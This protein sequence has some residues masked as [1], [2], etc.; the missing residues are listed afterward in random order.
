MCAE[1]GAAA[2]Y[3]CPGCHTQTCSLLCSKGAACLILKIM[4][5][6]CRSHCMMRYMLCTQFAATLIW[7]A[8]MLSHAEVAETC[9]DGDH[10][11]HSRPR[12][13]DL[14]AT[15]HAQ[16]APAS[17]TARHMCRWM[18]TASGTW[19]PTLGCS[20][21]A[22]VQPCA[23]LLS[24]IADESVHQTPH[25][26]WD[27]VACKRLGPPF[28]CEIPCLS[29]PQLLQAVLP[30]LWHLLSDSQD[31]GLKELPTQSEIVSAGSAAG[32]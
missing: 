3:T 24:A 22:S 29:A 15:R 7:A 21:C 12:G 30:S 27:C 20:R 14:Q 18:S 19:R 1:C 10:A 4:H 28:A 8:V 31:G 11:H 32:A 5:A 2:K 13:I 17:G 16:G 23:R 9:A 6:P 26:C 25:E